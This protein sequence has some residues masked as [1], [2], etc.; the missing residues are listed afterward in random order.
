MRLFSQIVASYPR[1]RPQ[2]GLFYLKG[3]RLLLIGLC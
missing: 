2:K 1:Y 3:T